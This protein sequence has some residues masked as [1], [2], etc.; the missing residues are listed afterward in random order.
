MAYI[1]PMEFIETPTF[2]R[3]ILELLTDEEYRG[4]QLSLKEHPDQ[5]VLIKGGGSLRKLRV[6]I[7]GKGKSGGARIIYYRLTARGQ[8]LLLLAYAKNR[9]D[10]LSAEETV[11]LRAL[12]EKE[13]GC[14]E[15]NYGQA[16]F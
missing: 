15:Q 14:K 9:K 13:F 16:T 1:F 12:A 11:L 7:R 2:T 10:D 8:I 3:L 6:A 5:G 4:L